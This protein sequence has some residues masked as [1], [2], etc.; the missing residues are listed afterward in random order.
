MV[1]K[2]QPKR[3]VYSPSSK[4]STGIDT[5]TKA[6]VHAKVQEL[7]DRELKPKHVKPPRRTPASTASRTS[8]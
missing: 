3:W 2:K 6:Q 1:K 5:A 4:A 7:I 8:L